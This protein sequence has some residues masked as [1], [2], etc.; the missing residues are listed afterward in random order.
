ME[1][2]Y[3][4]PAAGRTSPYRPPDAAG[5]PGAGNSVRR[6]LD[7]RHDLDLRR[8]VL[9]RHRNG[10][11]ARA[12]EAPGSHLDRPQ[13]FG[14][15]VGPQGRPRYVD[16]GPDGAERGRGVRLPGKGTYRA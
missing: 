2:R 1:R 16:P 9:A 5:R 6:L 7:L 3:L 12:R 11:R 10:D 8:G 14:A 13:R 15:M 4:A